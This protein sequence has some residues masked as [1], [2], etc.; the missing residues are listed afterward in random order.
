MRPKADGPQLLMNGDHMHEPSNQDMVALQPSGVLPAGLPFSEGIA[1]GDLVF[2]SGQIGNVPG[3][4][5]L[6]DGPADAEFKQVMDN[7]VAALK[8]NGLSTRNVVRCTVMLADMVDWPA[9]N[10]VYLTYCP[11]SD[12]LRLFRRLSNGGSGSSGFEVMRPAAGA[13][14]VCAG[15]SGA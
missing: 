14:S 5:N 8:A 2:L 6:A 11:S 12:D 9:F 7:I 15:L 13:A 1:A 10:Q 3:S 4:L